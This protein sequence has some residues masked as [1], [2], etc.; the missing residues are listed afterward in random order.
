[1][2]F[3]LGG[4]FNSRIN[5]NLR[6]EHGWTY[7]ARSRFSST[8]L[9]NKFIASAGVKKEATD[10]SIIEIVKEITQY[11][12]N[13]PTADEITFTK[14][15]M[16]QSEALDYETPGQKAGFLKMILKNNA[17]K[18]LQKRRTQILNNITVD[19]IAKL[20]NEYLPYNKL[21]IVIVGDKATVWDGIQK[22][23]Y[24]IIELDTHGNKI[25]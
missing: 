9:E 2:N 20:A 7:G 11:A 17:D 22:L 16:G 19:E 3:P 1:M 4:A 25:K 13:G 15:S 23:G 18:N 8:E 6:E 5:L 21:I 24:P 12:L 10:S 14:N